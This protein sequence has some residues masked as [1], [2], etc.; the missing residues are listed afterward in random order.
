MLA[1]LRLLFWE[2]WGVLTQVVCTWRSG[3]SRTGEVSTAKSPNREAELCQTIYKEKTLIVSRRC[4]EDITGRPHKVTGHPID[5]LFQND[6]YA[7]T[8][9]VSIVIVLLFCHYDKIFQF[10]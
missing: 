5:V 10:K 4:T 6:F 7:E 3:Q 1:V 9:W 8:V 2:I